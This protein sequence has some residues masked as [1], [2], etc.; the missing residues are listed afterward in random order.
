MTTQTLT[1]KEVV[2]NLLRRRGPQGACV[3]D[4]PIHISY[5]LRNR[6]GELIRDGHHI[7]KRRCRVHSHASA[8]IRYYLEAK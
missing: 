5:T 8:V 1:Y 2:L 7:T 3:S 4:V 6:A